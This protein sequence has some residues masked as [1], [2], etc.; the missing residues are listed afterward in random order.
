MSNTVERQ[1]INFYMF[2]FQTEQDPT[3]GS[4]NIRFGLE[5]NVKRSVWTISSDFG[6]RPITELFETE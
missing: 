1:N 2:G 5:P 6:H 4:R 3:F